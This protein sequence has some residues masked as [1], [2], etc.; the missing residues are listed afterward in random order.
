MSSKTVETP[1][2]G[3]STSFGDAFPG[4]NI[5]FLNYKNWFMDWV[6]RDFAH[7]RQLLQR[8]LQDLE[9]PLRQSLREIQKLPFHPEIDLAQFEF[10]HE[11][12]ANVFPILLLTKRRSEGIDHYTH[13]QFYDYGAPDRYVRTDHCDH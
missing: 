4:V 1:N 3:V 8:R 10:M 9:A 5:Y 7:Y 13:S 2:L 6:F 12:S 11:D